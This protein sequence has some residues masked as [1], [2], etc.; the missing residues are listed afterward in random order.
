MSASQNGYREPNAEKGVSDVYYI[1]LVVILE[2]AE[3]IGVIQNK[4]NHN[5]GIIYMIGFVAMPDLLII[6]HIFFSVAM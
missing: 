6:N 3:T 1:F 4:N 2:T 5:F